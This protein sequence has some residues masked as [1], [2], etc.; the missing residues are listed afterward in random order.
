MNNSKTKF[1]TDEIIEERMVA[2]GFG[3][4]KEG[5][6]E[7]MFKSVLEG[8]SAKITDEWWSSADWYI[9]EESTNDGYSVFVSTADKDNI[10][11]GSDVNYYDHELREDLIEAISN[12]SN[13]FVWDLDQPFVEDAIMELYGDVI[14]TQRVMVE[15]ELMDEGYEDLI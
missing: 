7:H 10:D 1:I 3:C 8:N 4:D 9:Y 15:D 12:S 13:I 14:E 6:E 5:D 11:I 2:K